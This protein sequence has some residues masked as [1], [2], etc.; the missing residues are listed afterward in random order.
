MKQQIQE[1]GVRKWFGDDFI[2]L[3]DELIE[4]MTAI[5]ADHGNF[6]ISGCT[7]ADLGATW[8]VDAGIVLLRD[9]AG[10]NPKICRYAGGIFNTAVA[11]IYLTQSALDKDDVPAY[12]RLYKDAAT[13]TQI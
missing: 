8:Q 2:A 13:S 10:D 4:A 7:V 11:Q 12:G 9:D 3:Q 1:N 6:I 5:F